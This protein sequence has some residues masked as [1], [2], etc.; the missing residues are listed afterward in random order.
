MATTKAKT[1]KLTDLA[2]AI[3]K[4]VEAS[5]GRKFPGGIIVGRMI[6]ANLASKINVNAVA[7]DITKQVQAAIPDA[8][9]TPKVIIDGG[10]TTMGFIFKPVEFDQ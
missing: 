3:D 7:R 10:I 6:P 2:Q 8:K 1:I 9:L 5:A 4:A